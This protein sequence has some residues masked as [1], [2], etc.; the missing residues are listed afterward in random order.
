METTEHSRAYS[1]LIRFINANGKERDYG[2][3]IAPALDDLYDWERD[4]AED[5]I[6]KKFSFDG[7]TGLADLVVALRNHNG[8]EALE[9][10]LREGIA[11][12][13]YS[14]RIVNIARVLYSA[15]SVDDYLEYIFEYYGKTRDRSAVAVLSYLKPCEKLYVFFTDLYLSSDD[16]V[17]RN[18]AV[19]GILC[20]KGYIKDPTDPKECSELT[21][22]A[23]AF[24]SDDPELRK[25]KLERFNNGEFDGIPRSYGLYRRLTAEEAIREANKPKE[26]EK[27]DET[28][29]GIIDATQSGVYFV[30]YE[31]EN[32]YIPSILSEEMDR[33]PNIGDR[34]Q[35]LKKQKGQSLILMI[36][37]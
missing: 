15:T 23:R 9:D 2:I 21:N 5:I 27:P 37:S 14:M 24:M 16:S 20:C 1:E 12:A 32:L 13:E 36:E 18:T 3:C 6:W 11:S 34:V 35:L 29:T 30:Y 4:E 8:I 28:V 31:E 22:M 10:K 7:D 17:I 25:K 26:P 33:K 19:T